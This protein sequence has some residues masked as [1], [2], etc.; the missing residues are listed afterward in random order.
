ML[1][2]S[3]I[4]GLRLLLQLSLSSSVHDMTCPSSFLTFNH[5][6]SILNVCVCSLIPKDSFLSNYCNPKLKLF[7][8]VSLN[9]PDNCSYNNDAELKQSVR[10]F[11][12]CLATPY[13]C[14]GGVD[15]GDGGPSHRALDNIPNQLP[16]QGWGIIHEQCFSCIKRKKPIQ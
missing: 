12:K 3:T 14:L 7:K 1:I 11:L 5:Y 15:G 2:F 8:L 6:Q 13:L 10:S 9:L 4:P 16:W